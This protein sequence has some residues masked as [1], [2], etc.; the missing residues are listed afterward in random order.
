[1]EKQWW[2]QNA[3]EGET[4]TD[5][6]HLSVYEP[7]WLRYTDSWVPSDL[8]E[9]SGERRFEYLTAS[10]LLQR[11]KALGKNYSVLIVQ[12]ALVEGER[13]KVVVEQRWI[14][15]SGSKWNPLVNRRLVQLISDWTIV[16]FRVDAETRKFRFDE[17]LLGGI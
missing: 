7:E 1:M 16:Y 5:Y 4:K 9:S 2:Y 3:D 14:D 11:R 12:P 6:K 8:L 10:E 15:I 13:V 17:V